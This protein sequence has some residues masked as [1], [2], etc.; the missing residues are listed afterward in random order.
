MSFVSCV[1]LWVML[2]IMPA[3]GAGIFGLELG[4]VTP[5]ATLILHWIYGAVLGG[6]FGSPR[7]GVAPVAARNSPP[8]TA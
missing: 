4:L 3:V 7:L 8:L 1:W 5:T 2:I 6:V